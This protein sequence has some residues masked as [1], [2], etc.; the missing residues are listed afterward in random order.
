ME[1]FELAQVRADR[2]AAGH[3]YHEF[4]RTHDLSAG[5]YELAAG[6]IDPQ[7]PHTE[8]EVYYVVSG[9]AQVRVGDDDARVG[10]DP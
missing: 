4:I 8:D 7:G 5:L 3:L 6:A 2:A 9:R 1:A 10:P